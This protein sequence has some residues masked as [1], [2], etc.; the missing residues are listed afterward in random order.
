M[1]ASSSLTAAGGG[2]PGAQ[3]RYARRCDQDRAGQAIDWTTP[4]SSPSTTTDAACPQKNTRTCSV[5]S[6]AEEVPRPEVRD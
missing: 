5:D 3:R 4:S 6:P 2:Q 1:S